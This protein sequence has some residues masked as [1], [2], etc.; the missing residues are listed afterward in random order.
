MNVPDKEKKKKCLLQDFFFLE[1]R[2]QLVTVTSH[3][4]THGTNCWFR[5]KA[6]N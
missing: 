4:M 6:I 3:V 5:T 1:N 2:G